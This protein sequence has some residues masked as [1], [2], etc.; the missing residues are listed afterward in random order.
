MRFMIFISRSDPM[1][2]NS[3]VKMGILF[4]EMATPTLVKL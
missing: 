1:T 4:T 2:Y 3:T